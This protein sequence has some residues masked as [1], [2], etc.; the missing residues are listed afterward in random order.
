MRDEREAKRAI[1]KYADTVRRICFVHLKNY[2]DTEDVF[3]EVFMKLILRDH[4]F[5]SEDHEKAWLIRV[6]VNACKDVLKSFFRRKISSIEEI[7]DEPS[8]EAD[9]ER[10]VLDA[11]LRLPENY[12]VVVYLHYYEGYSAPEIADILKRKENTI[13]T[14]L[15]RAREQLRV[16]LGGESLGEEGPR[17]F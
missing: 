17:R 4:D 10:E 3:Q 6:T 7:A 9:D 13:Y 11:V 15:S 16:S 14:W 5:K 1:D 2:R 12:R 8:Y